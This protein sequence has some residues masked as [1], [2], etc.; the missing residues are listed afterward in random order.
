MEDLLQD[1]VYNCIQDFRAAGIRVWMLTGD[2]G[3]TAKEIGISCGL[4]APDSSINLGDAQ[5][6][7]MGL[8]QNKNAKTS[9][10]VAVPSL[11][12]PHS[13]I[14]SPKERKSNKVQAKAGKK[15]LFEVEDT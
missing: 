14:Q 10:Y 8:A 4:V 11:P 6:I 1:N 13:S 7:A 2:K 3:V 9:R 15:N 12:V 5:D